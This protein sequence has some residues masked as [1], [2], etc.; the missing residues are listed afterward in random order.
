MLACSTPEP[1][2]APPA[3]AAAS[4]P[5][6]ASTAYVETGDLEALRARGALRVL[7]VAVPGAGCD[8]AGRDAAERELLALL[9]DSLDL[10]LVPLCVADA[11]TLASALR[12]GRG[13]LAV[14]LDDAAEGDALAHSVRR[15]VNHDWVLA[16]ADDPRIGSSD[17]LAGLRVAAVPGGSGWRRLQQWGSDRAGPRAVALPASASAATV[18][19][20]LVARRYDAALLPSSEW[21]PHAGI[22]ARVRIAFAAGDSTPLRW[23]VRRSAP[24]LLAALDH[25]LNRVQLHSRPAPLR[26]GDLAEIRQ[27]RVLRV[28][29]RNRPGSFFLAQG[30]LRGFEHDLLQRFA[31]S[32]GLQ[33]QLVMPPPGADLVAWLRDGRGDLVGMPLRPTAVAAHPGI[34]A[35]RAYRSGHVLVA[36]ATRS[37]PP[38]GPGALAG[39]RVA[40]LRGTAAWS[41]LLDL[42]REG[43]AVQA[44]AVA[45]G[46]PL[47]RLL[48]D[49]A[50][51]TYEFAAVV[52]PQA[53]TGRLL[54]PGVT[55]QLALGAPVP[56][57]WA[58]RDGNPQLHRALDAFIAAEYRGV[59]YN[60]LR[61][62]YFGQHWLPGSAAAGAPPELSPFDDTVR[63][64]AAEYGFDWRLIVAQMFQ[65]SRFDPAARS[66]AGAL[67]LM[68]VMPATLREMGFDGL[69]DPLEA[70]HAGVKYLAL[71]RDR[72]EREL[73]A[74]ERVW[75]ALA[76][77]NTGYSRV[78]A[79]RRLAGE[80]G[81]DPDRW[82][83]HVEQALA[84]LPRSTSPAAAGHRNC[85][86]GQPVVYVRA[87][88]A[89]Y[90]AYARIAAAPEAPGAPR[91]G[92]L[93]PSQAPAQASAQRPTARG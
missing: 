4:T 51:G 27:Q 11:A 50:A 73:P 25:H 42:Q 92:A 76:A 56:R 7:A 13:D 2:A 88:Q 80:L 68:Q 75:F 6:S 40:A 38:A 36:G 71:M 70:I 48:A 83:G 46:T 45:A 19:R 18:A 91:L 22:E 58:T 37:A 32:H 54:A 47:E 61:Q 1:V 30:D 65:E 12:A 81:L 39:R 53:Q 10:D 23:T 34:R 93:D 84:Q 86:C 64:L 77:Y 20:D 55:A 89:R 87:I 49:V 57:V 79:A 85:S 63:P 59:D 33:L 5:P 24:R 69:G 52:V 74:S 9:G 28:L 3:A 72:F 82:F 21:E 41:R 90:A 29:A 17:D 31:E 14:G 43:V 62:R 35:T 60:V 78:R 26:R 8:V 16:R 67:G 44:V 66:S 15:V